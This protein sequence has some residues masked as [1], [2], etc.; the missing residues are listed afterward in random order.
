MRSLAGMKL[1]AKS[2]LTFL[3]ISDLTDPPP[4]LA[5]CFKRACLLASTAAANAALALACFGVNCSTGIAART[6]PRVG[7]EVAVEPEW[8]VAPV[9]T[10]EDEEFL[11]MA[12][13]NA[14]GLGL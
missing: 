12:E 3:F 6:A 11:D 5:S 9:E 7:L 1:L 14:N 4:F 2:K 8:E 10:D 13:L